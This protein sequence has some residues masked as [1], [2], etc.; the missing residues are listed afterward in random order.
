MAWAK[1]AK[2]AEYYGVSVRTMRN[3]QAQGF[4]CVKVG[5]A[6]LFD[7]ERGDEW[8]RRNFALKN[9]HRAAVDDLLEGLLK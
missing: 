5:G 7:L 2:A 6:L 1:A 9:E 3:W 8:L 4:P